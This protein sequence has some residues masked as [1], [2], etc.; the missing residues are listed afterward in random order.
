MGTLAVVTGASRGLGAATARALAA[1]GFVVGLLARNTA[2]LEQ[3]AGTIRAAGGRALVETADITSADAVA[4]AVSAFRDRAGPVQVLVNN[5]GMVHPIARLGSLSPDDFDRTV[6]VNLHGAFYAVHAVLPD[7]LQRGAGCI[8]QVSSGAAHR[9]LEGWTSYCVGKAGLWMLTRSL[10]DEVGAAGV[11]VY[12]FQPGTVDTDMQAEIRRSG[13]NPVS[14]MARTD[15]LPPEV[16]AG[17]IAWLVR[18][19]PTEWHGED[20]RVDVV[21]AARVAGLPSR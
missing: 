7:M 19:Q 11:S 12:G 6:A 8:V 20:L 4:A 21:R 18:T 15:H 16:P 9:P 5:A 10:A 2:D 1:D 17:C 13:V 14:R 3:V